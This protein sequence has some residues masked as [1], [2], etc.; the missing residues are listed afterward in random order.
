MA[1]DVLAYEIGEAAFRRFPEL[2][3]VGGFLA[4]NRLSSAVAS[5]EPFRGGGGGSAGA[6]E[7][8]A[9]AHF[10]EWAALRQFGRVLVLDAHQGQ[11]L[12]VPED[13]DGADENGVAGGGLSDGAPVSGGHDHQADHQHRGQHDGGENKDGF[14]QCR[15]F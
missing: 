4:D 1:A 6:V 9:G 11:T 12:V 8:D 3:V 14:F 10:D 7:A 2:V 13:A 15:V 5:V